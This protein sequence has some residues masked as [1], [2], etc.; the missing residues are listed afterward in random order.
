MALPVLPEEL[1][2]GCDKVAVAAV[3]GEV[4]AVVLLHGGVAGEKQRAGTVGAGHRGGPVQAAQVAAQLLAILC[5]EATALLGAGQGSQW[6]TVHPEVLLELAGLREH[7]LT[8][9]AQ[10]A[11]RSGAFLC[12]SSG[13]LQAHWLTLAFAGRS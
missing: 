1:G 6:G 8:D 7:L 12:A 13:L 10:Q 9:G 5:G 11:L 4:C 3:E 2:I